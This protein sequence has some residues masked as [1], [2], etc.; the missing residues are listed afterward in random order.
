M[1]HS[2]TLP[3][4]DAS[5]WYMQTRWAGGEYTFGTGQSGQIDDAPNYQSTC[6]G[7]SQAA[8]RREIRQPNNYT[9]EDFKCRGHH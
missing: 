3:A 1:L 9:P 5:A 6:Q 7:P 2:P 4:G 8:G